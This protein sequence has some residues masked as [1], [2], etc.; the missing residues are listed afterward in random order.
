[1][2]LIFAPPQTQRSLQILCCYVNSTR[3]I[4][5][6]RITNVSDCHFE[7]VIFSG[8]RILFKAPR[9]A[10]L[11]IHTCDMCSAILSDKILCDRLRLD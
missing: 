3:K 5:I 1:M 2:A 7:R 10:Q 9:N 6:L 4:Q 11:E 8:Q